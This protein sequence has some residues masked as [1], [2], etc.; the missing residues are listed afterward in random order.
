MT[1]SSYK[2][3][4]TLLHLQLLQMQRYLLESRRWRQKVHDRDS[5]RVFYGHDALPG[6]GEKAGGGIIKCQDLAERFPNT[7]FDANILYLVSSALPHFAPLMV[8]IAKR[9]GVRLVWNQNGVAYPAWHGPG[10]DATNADMKAILPMADYVVY[11]S[12]FCKISADRYLGTYKGPSMILHNPVD[13]SF[14]IPN[15]TSPAGKFILLAGSHENFYRVRCAIEMMGL[16]KN[17]MPDVRL[18]VAGRYLWCADPSQAL[19]EAE[20]LARSLGVAQNISFTGSYSQEEVVPL[21]QSA[22]VLVHPKYND[23]CPRLVVEAMAC[24]LPVV[25]SASGG[26]PELV[27]CLAGIGV[28]APCDWERD[29]PPDPNQLA[30]AVCAVFHDYPAFRKAAR[31]RA[32]DNLDV[33][34]WLSRHE[35]VFTEILRAQPAS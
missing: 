31:A 17:R 6:R 29:H 30:E 18:R 5:I 32:V 28:E 26:V 35:E 15:Q 25:Y 21:M 13:T 9:Q 24:G 4:K 27:G 2:R 10:W 16:L 7:I 12:E 11:Q 19:R 8:R 3:F 34:L 23:P 20:D 22:N 14:F 1:D 33:Q